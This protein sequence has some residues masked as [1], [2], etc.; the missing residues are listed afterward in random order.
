MKL[1]TGLNAFACACSLLFLPPFV[2]MVRAAELPASI[3]SLRLQQG[4]SFVRLRSRLIKSGWAPVH[5]HTG[6]NYEY[7]GT[8][9]RLVERK[10][11]E[12]DSCST[13]R[14]SLCAL[15]YKKG[16][17]C[18]RVDTI[19][20]QVDSMQVTMWEESCPAAESKQLN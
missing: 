18:L 7:E 14:G 10:F 20:E 1:K 19:G 16:R 5:V 17:T 2:E 9:K 12:V 3:A 11:Y 6:Q 4:E 13:D 15:Y 8:E